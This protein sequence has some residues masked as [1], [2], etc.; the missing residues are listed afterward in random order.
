METRSLA[1]NE[2]IEN[3]HV[4]IKQE[5]V[6]KGIEHMQQKAIINGQNNTI[7]LIIIDKE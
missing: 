5:K 3:T 4:K 7:N 2:Y 6:D 1:P